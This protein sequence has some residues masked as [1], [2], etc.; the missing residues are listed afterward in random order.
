M[1]YHFAFHKR[2]HHYFGYYTQ[3]QFTY[4]T[5]KCIGRT[6][7]KRY[8]D[9]LVSEVFVMKTYFHSIAAM[10]FV[11]SNAANNSMQ[12]FPLLIYVLKVLCP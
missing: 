4:W 3:G 7:V 9:V 11:E 12:I 10:T 2:D 8:V 6:K 5:V 1:Q